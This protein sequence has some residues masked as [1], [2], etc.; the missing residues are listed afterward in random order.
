MGRRRSGG[1]TIRGGAMLDILIILV[2]VVAALVVFA[3]DKIRADFVS[4]ALLAV[5]LLLGQWRADFPDPAEALSGFSN[6]ATVTV[7]AMF[8]LSGALV[9]TGAINHLTRRIV[10]LGKHKPSRAF[11]ILIL[12]VGA[13][14][15]FVNN[16]ATLAVF[17]PITLALARDYKVSPS[18]VLMPLSYAAIVGGTCTLIGTS[19]NVL[20]SAIAEDHGLGPF[21]MFELSRLGLL[22]FAV[23]AVYVAVAQQFLPNRE[24]ITALT[25]KY[26]LGD[27]LSGIVVSENS[28]IVGKTPL[29]ARLAERYDVT[30]LQ[31]LREGEKRWF[32]IRHTKLQPG[33]RLL[34]RGHA[35]DIFRL[36]EMEGFRLAAEDKF[37]DE[38]LSSDMTALVE[39]VVSPNS[40]L[41][42]STLKEIDF[43]RKYGV[44][45]LAI[46]KHGRTIRKKIADIKLESGDTL[47][48]QG[49]RALMDGLV[50][51]PDLILLRELEMDRPRRT[52]AVTAIAIVASVVA[53]AALGF[54]PI[55]TAAVLGAVTMVATGCLTVKEAHESIDWM[56]IFLLAGVIPLGVAMEETGTAAFLVQGVVGLAD[57]FGAVGIVSCLYLLSSLLTAVMSNNA[58]A[59]LLAPIGIVTAHE[60]GASPWPFLMAITFGASAAFAT[61]VGYQTNMMVYG[62]G[63]YRYSD[64]LKMGIPLTL[65]FWAMATFLIPVFW[66]LYP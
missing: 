13:M 44:F 29:E 64:F 33:D 9:R 38:T 2:L 57:T 34:V 30:V 58:T 7:G 47:L 36:A 11:T 27:Y 21:G 20:V 40:A 65:I 23:G 26:R 60:L 5:L 17:L 48:L 35:D 49:R 46:R 54:F 4:I 3:T 10:A 53:A 14:S 6:Q 52:H 19:T 41:I 16:T 22:Y 37:R 31:I 43:R 15:A 66:P 63:R 32:G 12:T 18:R 28:P 56:V 45:A 50:G 51:D 61:P 25:R 1:R 24:H 55:V 59:I 42:G 8:I 62:P 39:C